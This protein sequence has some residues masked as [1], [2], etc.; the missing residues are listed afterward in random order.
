[1]I[2]T[3][4]Y[5]FYIDHRIST[6]QDS[7]TERVFNIQ[8]PSLFID[9]RIPMGPDF[10]KHR[11]L[12]TM[13]NEELRL[14]ARRHA[15]AGYSVLTT[16]PTGAKNSPAVCVR[17]HAIDWNFVG[18]MRSRPNKWRVEM[19]PAGDVWKEWGFA[20]DEDGQHV[21]MER[22]ERLP[23]GRGPCLALRRCG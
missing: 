7:N 3:I 16:D 18:R 9:I 22:W 8:S 11:S 20:K 13:S 2:C 1:M 6:F 12:D 21:Y 15:F 14:F 10:S 17:H 19:H 4:F 23:G 5:V